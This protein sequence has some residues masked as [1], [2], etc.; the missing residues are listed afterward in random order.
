MTPTELWITAGDTF[1]R[2]LLK[3]LRE[4]A[5]RATKK[6]DV[7]F[8]ENPGDFASAVY[9]GSEDYYATLDTN[10]GL[11]ITGRGDNKGAYRMIRLS[12]AVADEVACV[13]T[14][15]TARGVMDIPAAWAQRLLSWASSIDAENAAP[16]KRGRK[17]H[18]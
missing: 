8:A 2:A 11:L 4:D 10:G 6:W 1:A 7:H 12:S 18:A 13:L 15:E 17:K 16:A 9:E 3:D 14:H 5:N